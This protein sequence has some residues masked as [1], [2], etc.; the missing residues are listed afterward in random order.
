ME[1]RVLGDNGKAILPGVVPDGEV[2]SL[3]QVNE[4]D[5]RRAWISGLKFIQQAERQILIQ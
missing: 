5:L 2:V 4:F 3:V 1:I